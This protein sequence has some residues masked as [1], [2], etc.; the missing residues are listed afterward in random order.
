MASSNTVKEIDTVSK[1][2]KN[3]EEFIN[4]LRE[5]FNDCKESGCQIV[6]DIL[7]EIGIR[8]IKS[9][10]T[11]EIIE[12]LIDCSN[13][14]WEEMHEKNESYFE[15]NLALIFSGLK[16]ENVGLFKKLLVAQDENGELIVTDIDRDN[17]WNYLHAFIKLTLS[18]IH[19]ERG[20]MLKIVV[21]Q[22][23][24]IMT[25]KNGRALKTPIYTREYMP[26]IDLSK[27]FK[28]YRKSPI[29]QDD[30]ID[31]ITKNLK[32]GET[33]QLK[34]DGDTKIVQ[35]DKNNHKLY[36]IDTNFERKFTQERYVNESG[37][38][39]KLVYQ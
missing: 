32:I 34:I 36:E 16:M 12:S 13:Y 2:A 22:Q 3:I 35:I 31:K 23:G 28:L 17:I 25:D 7:L 21:N 9:Y 5:I 6:P 15:K 8:E 10:A 38:P 37:D 39:V 27:Y 1:F 29:S 18:F 19:E 33:Y 24:K 30:E 26:K 20:P 11:R 14:H 4:M